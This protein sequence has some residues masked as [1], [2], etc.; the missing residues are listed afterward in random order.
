MASEVAD[1]PEPDSPTRPRV[2]PGPIEKEIPLTAVCWP[3]AMVRLRTSS[4]GAES[5]DCMVARLTWLDLSSA[6]FFVLGMYSLI[7]TEVGG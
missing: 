3:K 7:C 6:G 4:R 5:I 1:L 2:S